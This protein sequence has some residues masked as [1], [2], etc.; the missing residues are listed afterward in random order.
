[1]LVDIVKIIRSFLSRLEL[2]TKAMNISDNYEVYQKIT[3]TAD[4]NQNKIV[5][6][7]RYDLC[8]SR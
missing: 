3:T 4:I 5:P 8:R 2:L 1:M 7:S 6:G